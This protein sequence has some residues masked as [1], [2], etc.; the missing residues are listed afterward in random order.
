MHKLSPRHLLPLIHS[1]VSN[2]SFCGQQ[3][4]TSDCVDAKTELGLRY[5]H[6]PEGIFSHGVAHVTITVVLKQNSI[7]WHIC[8]IHC[9]GSN[10]VDS[11]LVIP[12]VSFF[13]SYHRLS[14]SLQL[15][16]AITVVRFKWFL[17]CFFFFFFFLF[18]FRE[19]FGNL[20]GQNT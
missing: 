18:F 4:S 13:F 9:T 12:V 17:L 2:D 1:V 11:S 8:L 19:I 6:M 15:Y 20:A 10:E 16:F 3:R 5:L 7:L 14:T